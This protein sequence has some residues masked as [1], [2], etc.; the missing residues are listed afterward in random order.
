M[1]LLEGQV[2]EMDVAAVPTLGV[3]P[4]EGENDDG[5]RFWICDRESTEGDVLEELPG[6][7]EQVGGATLCCAEVVPILLRSRPSC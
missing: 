7:L 3:D 2:D 4:E 1:P 5:G 6:G